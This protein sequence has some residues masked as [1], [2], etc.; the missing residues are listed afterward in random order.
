MWRKE[1][2]GELYAY[3][4]QTDGNAKAFENAIPHTTIPNDE[5]G[6]SVGRG[7]FTWK[8]GTWNHISQRAKLNTVGKQDGQ[9]EIFYNGKSIIQVKDLEFRSDETSLVR[10]MQIQTFFGGEL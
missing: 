2:A 5:Y 7:T 6:T 8:T 9:V 10:G 3:L 4:P 1:A